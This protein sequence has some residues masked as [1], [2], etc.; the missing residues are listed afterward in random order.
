MFVH[1]DLNVNSVMMKNMLRWREIP[2]FR[3][4][5]NPEFY[6]SHMSQVYERLLANQAP[7]LPGELTK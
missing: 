3:W 1:V 4:A 7:A 6:P 2:S 5:K